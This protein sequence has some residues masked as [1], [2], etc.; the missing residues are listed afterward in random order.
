MTTQKTIIP[1]SRLKLTLLTFGAL[2]FVVVGLIMIAKGFAKFELLAFF[3]I[4]I[5]SASFTFF[6]AC[7][8]FGLFRL[9]SKKPGLILT[10]EGFED[11]SSFLGGHFIRWAD[12]EEIDYL[13]IQNQNIIRVI[14]KDPNGFIAQTKGLQKFVM[15]LNYKFYNSPIHISANSLT[16]KFSDL[17]EKFYKT[18]QTSKQ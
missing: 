3:G 12:V 8:L 15:R 7:F 9:F 1:I 16:Y 18:W 14:L 13:K 11:H 2:G 17:Q 6:G 10:H 5:G 4:I